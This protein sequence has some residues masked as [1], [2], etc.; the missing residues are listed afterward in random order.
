MGGSAVTTSESAFFQSWKCK[1]HYSTVSL[2]FIL[3][4]SHIKMVPVNVEV[5]TEWPVPE[6]WK[7]LQRFLSF[8]NFYRWFIKDNSSIEAPLQQLTSIKKKFL[9][10]PEAIQELT[11]FKAWFTTAPILIL[12]DP[13]RQFVVEVDVSDTRVGAVRSQRSEKDNSLHPL[14]I[15]LPPFITK[16]AKLRH[17]RQEAA[18]SHTSPGRMASLVRGGWTANHHPEWWQA[19]WVSKIC[20]VLEFLSGPVDSIFQSLSHH[21]LLPSR[22]QEL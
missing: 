4:A 7:Q 3:S 20:K 6:N 1:F 13:A 15:L 11:L 16:W 17:R 5:L 2:E 19:P 14:S 22:V 12:P 8:A 21:P 9:W 10:S 18:D